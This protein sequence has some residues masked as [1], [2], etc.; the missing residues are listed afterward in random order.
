M[1]GKGKRVRDHTNKGRSGIMPSEKRVIRKSKNVVQTSISEWMTDYDITHSQRISGLTYLENGSTANP[2]TPDVTPSPS[3][4]LSISKP[5]DILS[6]ILSQPRENGERGSTAQITNATSPISN[7]LNLASSAASL[8][9]DFAMCERIMTEKHQFIVSMLDSMNNTVFSIETKVMALETRVKAL[10]EK[11]PFEPSIVRDIFQTSTERQNNLDKKQRECLAALNSVSQK[12]NQIDD[13]TDRIHQ[14]EGNLRRQKD[15]TGMTTT[16]LDNLTI[17]IFGLHSNGDAM[18]TVNH[19]FADMDLNFRCVSAYRTPPRPELQRSGVIIAS[20]KSLNDKREILTRKRNLRNIPQYRNVFLKPSKSHSEQVMD[21]NF[22]IM[23]NEMS[24]GEEY[25][26]SDNGRI[27]R[28]PSDTPTYRNSDFQNIGKDRRT[29][30]GFGGARSKTTYIH[31]HMK[32]GH[33]TKD[34]RSTVL[35]TTDHESRIKDQ[36]RH[37][38][39]YRRSSSD[40]PIIQPHD[41]DHYSANNHDNHSQNGQYTQQYNI[42]QY[43]S[44]K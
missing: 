16:P 30:G 43:G 12:C 40:R 32:R 27:R 44:Q 34:T 6:P 21:A 20:L 29:G 26:L 22:T 14:I 1:A 33:F 17:A 18:T 24:N 42:E 38:E 28:R 19:L 2:K 41:Y 13:L 11:E 15:T 37:P 10:E 35:N 23:L 5:A 39:A 4:H 25:F 3:S 36:G 31:N 7:T 8:R 9:N